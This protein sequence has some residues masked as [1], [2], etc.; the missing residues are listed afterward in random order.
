VATAAEPASG[1]YRPN[2]ALGVGRVVAGRLEVEGRKGG[3][4]EGGKGGWEGKV[5]LEMGSAE[6]GFT[7]ALANFS[8]WVPAGGGA[9]RT[10]LVT[11]WASEG[12]PAYRTFVLGGRGTLVG[13]PFRAYGGRQLTLVRVDWAR[14]IGVPA[15]PLGSFATTGGR[16]ILAPF[17]AAGWTGD[18]VAGQPWAAT[19]GIRPVVG[20]ASELLFRMI[21][22]E[23]GWAIRG[24]RFGVTVDASPPWWPIL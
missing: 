18:P 15:V 5:G 8:A 6:R 3:T 17:V 11:G 14:P 21:R 1:S 23:A 12:T 19:A 10:T 16:A 2:P 9:L 22:I 4:E 20:V 24:G 13:E 7:R